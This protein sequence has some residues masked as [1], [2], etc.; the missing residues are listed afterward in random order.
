MF[1]ACYCQ[2]RRR[3]LENNGEDSNDEDFQQKK[4][5]MMKE[6]TEQKMAVLQG[7]KMDWDTELEAV[8]TLD[9]L[10]F[11]KNRDYVKKS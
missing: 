6:H 10:L 4:V 1:C 3:Q 5:D 9:W 2:V 8:S 11:T 7:K